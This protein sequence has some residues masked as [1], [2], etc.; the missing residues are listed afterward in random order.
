MSDH[1]LKARFDTPNPPVAYDYDRRILWQ[2]SPKPTVMMNL[3]GAVPIGTEAEV[4]VADSPARFEWT[5]SG[6]NEDAGRIVTGLWI[7]SL[8]FRLGER[9][10]QTFYQVRLRW[11]GRRRMQ[12]PMV[13]SVVIYDVDGYYMGDWYFQAFVL[14]CQCTEHS[15]AW[16]NQEDPVHNLEESTWTPLGTGL[17]N[18]IKHVGISF[19]QGWGHVYLAAGQYDTDREPDQ[20]EL[21]R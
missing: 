8:R 18:K 1:K 14:D 10:G 9:N 6:A 15:E 17:L 20:G 4:R 7:D 5:Y 3:Q 16:V 12:Q 19:P 13:P 21:C 2:A 11:W